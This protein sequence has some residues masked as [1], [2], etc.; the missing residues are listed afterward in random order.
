MTRFQYAVIGIC[1]LLNAVDGFDVMATAFTANGLAKEWTLTPAALGF[2]LSAGLFGMTIGSLVLAPLADSLGSRRVILLSITLATAG[3]LL[4][5]IAQSAGQLGVLRLVTGVGVGGILACTNVLASEYSSLRRRGL[6]VSIYA[7]GYPIG[8]TL[9]GF[10]AIGLQSG[11]GWRAVFLCGGILSLLAMAGTALLLPESAEF[12]N[13]RQPRNALQKINSIARKM[14]HPPVE[15]LTP[16]RAVQLRRGLK[17]SRVARLLSAEYRKRTILLWITYFCVLG[18]YYFVASWTPRLL[19]TAGM[20]ESQGMTGGVLLTGGGVVGTIALGLLTARFS[21]RKVLIVYLGASAVFVTVFS[22]SMGMLTLALSVAAAI[23][24]ATVACMAGLY[25]MTPPLFEPSIRVTAIGFAS[26]MGR[27]GGIV[28]PI[29]TGFL[30]QASWTPGQL[31]LAV[32]GLFAVGAVSMIFLKVQPPSRDE[33]VL[34]IAKERV[35]T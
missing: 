14:G 10:A 13:E 12:L 5:A 33:S 4:S 9:G 31:Y 17:S 15:A 3:M 35:T 7:L 30:L 29:L 23:G 27:L 20:S 11:F 19:V 1:F 6:A 25:A 16:R 8:A 22:Q 2:L 26:G 21:V 32:G 34:T 28:A 18:G 24:F